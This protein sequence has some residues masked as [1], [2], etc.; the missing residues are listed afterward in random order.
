MNKIAVIVLG[1]FD[2]YHDGVVADGVMEDASGAISS[3]DFGGGYFFSRPFFAPGVNG[4]GKLSKDSVDSTAGTTS[5][6]L[7]H[8]SGSELLCRRCN[9]IFHAVGILRIIYILIEMGLNNLM[10]RIELLVPLVTR[11]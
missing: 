6:E 10:Y 8:E 1:R 3:V 4:V 11:H 5:F 2:C 7:A 9:C